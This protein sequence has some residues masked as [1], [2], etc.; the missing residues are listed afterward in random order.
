[1]VGDPVA[2]DFHDEQQIELHAA[3]LRRVAR[4]L[5]AAE[6]GVED[7]VQ[8]TLLRA[9]SCEST[10]QRQRSWLA[11]ACRNVFV[12]QRRAETRRRE[13]ER[14][15]AR[16]EAAG[17]SD[18]EE[19]RAAVRAIARAITALPETAYS[20]IRLR[21]FD[22]VAPAEIAR[23]LGVPVGTVKR[24]LDRALAHLRRSLSDGDRPWTSIAAVLAVPGPPSIAGGT[25][26]GAEVSGYF[27]GGLAMAKAASVL[28]FVAI[29]VGI[30]IWRLDDRGGSDSAPE[31]YTGAVTP[32]DGEDAEDADDSASAV[33]LDALPFASRGEPLLRLDE[34]DRD[35]DVFGR[36]IDF[37]GNAVAGAMVRGQDSSWRHVNVPRSAGVRPVREA[38]RSRTDALGQFILPHRR[39]A[40]VDLEIR[41][42]GFAV[43][44][45]V[46]RVAGEKVLIRLDRPTPFVVEVRDA[47][48]MPVAGATVS[49]WRS[50]TTRPS[51]SS[52]DRREALTDA[53]GRCSFVDL[54]EGSITVSVEHPQFVTPPWTTHP[55]VA[56]EKNVVVVTLAAGRTIRGRVVEAGTKRPIELAIVGQGTSQRRRVRT[57]P[58]GEYVLAGCSGSAPLVATAEGFGSQLAPLDDET[59]DFVL[60]PADTVTGVVLGDDGA[61]VSD[62]LVTAITSIPGAD[63]TVP[64]ASSG[65]TD[66]DGRFELTGLGQAVR[67]TLVVQ[68]V[69]HGRHLVDFGPRPEGASV[70]DLGVIRLARGHRLEGRVLTAEG[71][72]VPNV[73]VDLIGFNED[74]FRFLPAETAVRRVEYGHEESRR[75]D[76]LGRFR[77]PDLSP[78][79]YRLCAR[80]PC[81]APLV[82]DIQIAPGQDRLDIEF[83]Y[84]D[85][86]QLVVVL[87]DQA[88]LPVATADVALAMEDPVRHVRTRTDNQ[89]RAAFTG[90]EMGTPLTVHLALHG[91]PYLDVPASKHVHDGTAIVI[92]LKTAALVEGR[93]IQTDGTPVPRA[94]VEVHSSDTGGGGAATD[95]EGW[96]RI[97]LPAGAI[98]DLAVT[99]A[100]VIRAG[101]PA[102]PTRWRG[103]VSGV[104]VPAN[105]VV[106][107]VS[108]PDPNRAVTVR[109]LT[110]DGI[111]VEGIEV[112]V[113][114]GGI[115][116]RKTTN[117]E[118]TASFMG[119]TAEKT[120]IRTAPDAGGLHVGA[121]PQSIIPDGQTI[122]MRLRPLMHLTGV[123][124]DHLGE[125]VS[126][127][128]VEALTEEYDGYAAF[129]DGDGRFRLPLA[130]GSTFTVEATYFDPVTS[131]RL[132]VVKKA[133]TGGDLELRFEKR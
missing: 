61:S 116:H 107:V 81:V 11:R 117:G 75:T 87:T 131:D 112:F 43:T 73:S 71:D 14:R 77:F 5:L 100:H 8:E 95:E 86:P 74:R 19:H 68:A 42:T 26:A 64:D 76:D 49:L 15:V 48:E 79:L 113:S 80:R 124:R 127:A 16:P 63:G 41:A 103:R 53:E 40:L 60:T 3:F 31:R 104:T 35:H 67:R 72:P 54:G 23:R 37:D 51:G 28:G 111:P 122:E 62:A 110:P 98:V 44:H 1:M 90:I 45:V 18:V 47:A 85:A 39:G 121:R 119:L 94:L 13:R 34:A 78:G 89:G 93:V 6:Q 115:V 7:L 10:P 99:G 123:V 30:L 50:D 126:N 29:V 97:K 105:D 25:A 91:T 33:L 96:F 114:N 84:S 92:G 109:V 12:E 133:V 4:R 59:V 24:R 20:V 17:R 69:G 120:F 108:E 66:T 125:P 102:A 56:G 132:R 27:M 21:Y 38:A 130:D 57:N 88:G 128:R 101:P 55:I 82:A 65:L 52:Y 83:Q 36:V 9:M 32:S 70:I 106:I 118:A 2:S 129:S 22:G 58:S 46:D